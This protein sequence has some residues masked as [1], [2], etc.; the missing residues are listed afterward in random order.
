MESVLIVDDEAHTRQ[1]LSLALSDNYD[2]SCAANAD[3][4]LRVM[5]AQQFD[6][7]ITDL[8]MSGK[9]GLNLIDEAILMPNKPA[10]IMM[11]AYGNIDVAVE[12]MKHG[13]S[14]FL[15]KPIDISRLESVLARALKK[16]REA[17]AAPRA[18]KARQK[19]SPRGLE[20]EIIAKSDLMKGVL[21]Q[22]LK[23]APTKAT[24]MITGETGTGKEL[25]AE[26][27]HKNSPRNGANFVPVHCAAIP[28]NLIESELFGYEKGAFTGAA[29][30]KAGRFELSD[31]GT[32]FLD[33]IGEIDLPAQV[34]LLRFLETRKIERLGGVSEIPLD[35]RLVCATNRNLKEMA[36]AG[37]FREDLYYR[38]NVVEIHLPP[39]RERRQDIAPL[40]EYY[41][42]KYAEENGAK[43][44]KVSP[45]TMEILENYSWRGNI[46]E[47]RN[48]CE[49]AVVLRNSDTIGESSLDS[50]FFEPE[51]EEPAAGEFKLSSFDKRENELALI[52]KAIEKCGGNKTRAAE[53]LGI[54][55]RTLHR[56]LSGEAQEK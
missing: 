22:A 25:I 18:E 12:A 56:K 2:V 17:L 43:N 20:S 38:L 13:A 31:G 48:F 26:F 28:A 14:D 44:V 45:K 40:I 34:K 15:T 16:R 33:E 49:N 47:L 30:R 19:I 51:P 42:A 24:V 21:R 55:R 10:C 27:I 46:R 4:A 3:E 50:R 9:S 29:A 32:L 54:S 8:R 37:D 5:Q 41:I 1:G 11:T 6:A 35:I 36:K 53:L 7:I 39:L 23:V 52:K